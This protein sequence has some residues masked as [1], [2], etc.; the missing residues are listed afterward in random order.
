MG[1]VEA[2][3]FL[4]HVGG[5]EVEQ[6]PSWRENRKPEC[7]KVSARTRSFASLSERSGSPMHVSDGVPGEASISIRT[8]SPSTPGIAHAKPQASTPSLCDERTDRQG[9]VVLRSPRTLRP[10]LAAPS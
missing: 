6:Q 8:I 3:P 7:P 2:R 4:A 10:R 5:S 1:K 9:K